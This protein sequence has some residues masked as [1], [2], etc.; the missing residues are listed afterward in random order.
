MSVQSE[1][2]GKGRDS[3]HISPLLKVALL[4]GILVHLSGFFMFRVISNSLPSREE[5]TAFISLVPTDVTGYETELIEQ[6]SLFDSAPLFIPGAWSSASGVFSSK[7]LRDWQVFPDFEPSIELMDEV[8]P[9]RLSLHHAAGLKEPSDLLGLRFWDLFSQFGQG[10]V[11]LDKPKDRSSVAVATIISG[12]DEY[13]SGSDVRLDAKLQSEAF[14]SRLLVFSLNM[15]APGLPIG[16]PVLR[17]SSG[18]PSLDA[19]VLEWLTRPETLARL[20][21]GFLELRVFP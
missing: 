12:N 15:S 6:A 18:S 10:E 19:E 4:L 17:E 5:T 13:P 2:T 11:H 9:G 16:A 3:P 14:A 20:P 7:I 8:K 1:R 21:A